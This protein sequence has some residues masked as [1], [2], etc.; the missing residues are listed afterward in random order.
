M[1]P[2]EHQPLITLQEGVFVR[3]FVFNQ[4]NTMK[5]LLFL[6]KGLTS[7]RSANI[8]S[9]QRKRTLLNLFNSRFEETPPGKRQGTRL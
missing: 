7:Q 5:G 6:H 8:R 3:M 9:T 4:T 1:S 2:K